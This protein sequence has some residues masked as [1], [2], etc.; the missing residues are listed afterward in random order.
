MIDLEFVFNLTIMDQLLAKGISLREFASN[1][2]ESTKTYGFDGLS[3]N[4]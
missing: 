2:V 4:Y 3:M 1:L